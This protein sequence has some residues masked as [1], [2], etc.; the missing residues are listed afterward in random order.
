M[1]HS[2]TESMGIPVGA[3]RILL[4]PFTNTTNAYIDLLRALLTDLGYDVQPLS[5]RGLLR[6]GL[7]DLFRPS[8]V[9]M[10][11]WIELRAFTSGGG[12]VS[13]SLKGAL[14]FLFY[15]TLMAIGRAKVVYFV[16][17][18]AIHNARGKVRKISVGLMSL[19]RW[20]ADHRV[21]HAPD[22][23]ARYHARYLPHPLYWDAPGRIAAQAPGAARRR[24]SPSFALLGKIEPYKDVAAL[25]EVWPQEA[26]LEIAGRGN[27][28]YIET[29]RVIVSQRGIANAVTID[30]RFLGDEEFE[31]KLCAADVI[32]LPH[33]EDSMLVS[34][35]FFEAIGRVPVL[36]ARSVPFMVW[37]AQRF[38]NV[39]LF[40]TIEQLPLLVRSIVQRWPSLVDRRAVQ[41]RVIEAFGWQACRRDYGEFFRDVVGVRARG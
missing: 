33:L 8:T 3:P 12:R 40:D 6:G 21:V 22:F 35:A 19:V 31:E 24:A 9:L 7:I 26:A 13:L 17:D 5:V 39:F 10:F 25:L 23:E 15:C 34:G 4:S 28:A 36:I 16:H 18:H 38:D 37:A 11:H 14:V 29:L 2:E 30:A 1:E 27:A 41:N 32:V 20:L